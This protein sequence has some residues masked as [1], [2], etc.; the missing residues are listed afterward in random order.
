MFVFRDTD[1]WSSTFLERYLLYIYTYIKLI[2]LFFIG[3]LL[4]IELYIV[5]RK[6]NIPDPRPQPPPENQTKQLK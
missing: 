4:Y 3:N 6:K 2:Y 1:I 5:T